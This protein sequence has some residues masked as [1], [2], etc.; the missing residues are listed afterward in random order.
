MKTNGT[1]VFIEP[2]GTLLE[3]LVERKAWLEKSMPGQALCGHPPHC[4]LFYGDYGPP[5]QW[6]EDLRRSAGEL[7]AFELETDGW[8]EFTDDPMTG[9][10]QTVAFRAR[11]SEELARLQRTVADCLAPFSRGDAMA[12][13]LSETEPFASSLRKFDFP[14]V[15]THWIPHFTI[16]SPLVEPGSPLVAGLKSGSPSHRFLVRKISVWRVD[17]DKHERLD[18]LAL[19]GVQSDDG[20]AHS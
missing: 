2:K 20:V 3:A 8:Q 9:G 15:G 12:H 16:G 11:L 13:P 18:E 6:I 4:T 1:A 10:G 19:S 14:F 7:R 17:G 5:A